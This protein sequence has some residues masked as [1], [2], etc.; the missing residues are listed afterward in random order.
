MR[1]L[2]N[3]GHQKTP[4]VPVQPGEFRVKGN[5]GTSHGLEIEEKD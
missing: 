3:S 2:A 5:M 4:K 1:P